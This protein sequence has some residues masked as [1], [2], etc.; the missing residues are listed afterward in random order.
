MA[1][2]IKDFFRSYDTTGDMIGRFNVARMDRTLSVEVY[3][4]YINEIG[5]FVIQR[6]TTDG[7]TAIKVYK[8]YAKKKDGAGFAA[9][10]SSRGTLPFVEYY[11]LFRQE[12]V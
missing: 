5:S 7:T 4:A 12:G 1:F 2:E 11:Q 10:W 8:Y 3:N 9:A 6:T